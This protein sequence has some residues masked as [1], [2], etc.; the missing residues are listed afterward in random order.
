MPRLR[1]IRVR[2]SLDPEAPLTSVSV[3]FGESSKSYGFLASVFDWSTVDMV[4]KRNI[5]SSERVL[6]VGEIC[7]DEF[8]E[9]P[10]AIPF[11]GDRRTYWQVFFTYMGIS[12]KLN[13]NNAEVAVL[14]DDD[15]R[16]MEINIRRSPEGIRVDFTCYTGNA[17]FF[18]KPV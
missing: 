9:V 11:Q 12:Y 5:I 1:A 2:N 15:G 14:S 13:T 16:H 7:T 3:V 18:A 6:F 17:F 4:T 8:E 10:R